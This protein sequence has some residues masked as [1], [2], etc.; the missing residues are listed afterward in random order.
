MFLD[1]S[2]PADV[3]IV[4]AGAIES[5]QQEVVLNR[6]PAWGTWVHQTSLSL[7]KQPLAPDAV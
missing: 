2:V 6:V 3:A 7:E 4:G 5:V 1:G